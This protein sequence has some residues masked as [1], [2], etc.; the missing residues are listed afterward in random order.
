MTEQIRL[1]TPDA[2]LRLGFSQDTLRVWARGRKAPSGE[3]A[4][5]PIFTEGEHW[6]RRTP[7]PNS[8]IVFDMHRCIETLRDLG[9]RIEAALE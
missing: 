4:Q 3:W 5:K 7:S 2:A 1:T 8:P 6:S 9:Y